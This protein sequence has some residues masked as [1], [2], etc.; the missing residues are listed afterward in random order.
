VEGPI[1]IILKIPQYIGLPGRSGKGGRAYSLS[2]RDLTRRHVIVPVFV[3]CT[4]LLLQDERAKLFFH[5]VEECFS[6]IAK[7]CHL[8]LLQTPICPQHK[9][10]ERD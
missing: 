8:F 6:K 4:A 2:A 9:I 1:R 5:F 3:Y 7:L 10:G